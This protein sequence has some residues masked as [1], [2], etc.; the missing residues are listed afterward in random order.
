LTRIRAFAVLIA[1]VAAAILI[2]ACG[3]GSDNG[4]DPQQVLDETFQKDKSI[5]SGTF[6]LDVKIVANGGDN[7]GRFEA[8]LGGPFQGQADKFPQFNI[9]VS[10]KAEG[11]SQ[12]F[13]GTGG[14]TS[15]GEAAFVNFQGTEYAVDQELFDQ[16]ISTYT[17]LQAQ[18]GSQNQGG[19]LLESLGIEPS[20]WLTDLSNEGTE[21]VGGTDTIHISGKADIPRL[22]EDLKT[23]AQKAGSAVGSI[24]TDQ[25]DQLND[26]V[27]SAD[28]D[29]YTGEDDKVLRRLSA[30]VELEP[31]DAPGA[32]DSLDIDFEIT[33][34]DV[35]QPQTIQAPTGAQPLSNLLR[36]FGIDPGKLGQSLRGSLGASG[37][38]PETGGS[39]TT[40]SGESTQAYLNCL[41]QASGQAAL[42]KCAGLLGK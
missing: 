16:F 26:T 33:L 4:E 21:D 12:D 41:Q 7:A 17:Q 1:A 18:S 35:N 42:Q 28:F 22:V 29:V 14:L 15:T 24:P 36:Q 2:S 3:G 37:A 38:L 11:G 23:I 31:R 9:D 27:K 6:D 32:P 40:P 5:Q 19:G 13:F 20:N 25:L 10:L 39:T 30:S 34:G 8:K